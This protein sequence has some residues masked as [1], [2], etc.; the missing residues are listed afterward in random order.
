MKRLFALLVFVLNVFVSTKLF[1][2]E[3]LISQFII[4]DKDNKRISMMENP[5]QVIYE[6]FGQKW[7][8]GL[9]KFNL[10]GKEKYGEVYT[11]LDANKVCVAKNASYILYGYVQKSD[12]NYFANA[13]FYDANKKKIVK[14]FFASDDTEH[15]E[16][17]LENLSENIIEEFRNLFALTDLVQEEKKMRE[18]E[19]N[20]PMT[21]FYW[22]PIDEKWT[23]KLLG[24]MGTS[25][26][27]EFYPKQP[28]MVLQNVKVDFFARLNIVYSIGIN[29][30]KVYPFVF[31]SLQV[32]S[33]AFVHFHFTDEH[34]FYFGLG[35]FYEIN[36]MNIKQRHEDDK[37]LYEN[38]CGLNIVLGYEYFFNE[39]V[40][41]FGEIDFD[42]LFKADG[43]VLIKPTFGVSLNVLRK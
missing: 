28:D 29:H 20:L 21:L 42:F 34:S 12:K 17:M 18:V 19:V 41:F 40:S 30:K 37:L 3:I 11:V 26:G 23:R 32:A 2:E 14:E 7:F 38:A 16:R 22:N 31:N 33:P 43:L 8:E 9:L 24:V 13:K 39:R 25:V 1:A 35:P 10:L 6:K 4:F 27:V 36:F 5:A 15:Y